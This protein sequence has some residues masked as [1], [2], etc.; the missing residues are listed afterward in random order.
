MLDFIGIGARRAG[1]DWLFDHLRRHPEIHFPREIEVSFWSHHYPLSLEQAEYSRDLDWYRSIFA[2][3]PDGVSPTVREQERPVDATPVAYRRN[4]FDKM[5]AKLDALDS[6]DRKARLADLD[7]PTPE[8]D[9]A[10]PQEDIVQ[11]ATKLG[12]FSPTYC[13]FDEPERVATVHAFAPDAKILYIVRDP[14]ARAWAAAE[15]LR[16]VAGLGEDEVSDVWYADHFASAQSQ[17]HGDY[18]R[19]IS[20]W[21]EHYGD[22]LLVLRYEDIACTPHAVLAAACAHIGVADAR[23][24]DAEPQDALA[25][26]LAA[27]TPIRPSLQ[28]VLHTLY[29]QKTEALHELTAIDYRAAA[30]V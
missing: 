15:K 18:A 20:Q 13:W 22:N 23:Y 11:A 2:H 24:F 26:G 12:D 27:D 9:E 29:A 4:W 3:W 19:A 10:A 17:R 1:E 6:S 30:V 8:Q 16:I 21:R 28:P 7:A 14:H 5:M 25:K